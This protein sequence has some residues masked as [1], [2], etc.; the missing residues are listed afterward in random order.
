MR[1]RSVIALLAVLLTAAASDE[2][3]PEPRVLSAVER[4]RRALQSSDRKALDALIAPGFVMVHSTGAVEHRDAYLASLRS[5]GGG[6]T[7]R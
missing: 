5:A 1:R 3:T 7:P 4:L 2:T 6:H